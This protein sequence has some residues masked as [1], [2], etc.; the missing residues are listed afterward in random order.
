MAKRPPDYDIAAL[1]RT[2]PS[3][4]NPSVGGAWKNDDGTI[5][6]K[7][8][9]FVVLTGGPDL[10]LTL[11]PAEE[12]RKARPL[13]SAPTFAE[14][15]RNPPKRPASLLDD[16]IPFYP[17]VLIPFLEYS[18][19]LILAGGAISELFLHPHVGYYVTGRSSY[20]DA[21]IERFQE[22]ARDER[23]YP[24]RQH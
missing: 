18:P 16:D 5:T 8:R 20:P 15:R 21:L 12:N 19:Q 23:R 6:I 7:I 3:A 24:S 2:S 17:I 22:P 11:F 13:A 4:K 14:K 9:P 1:D 10:F